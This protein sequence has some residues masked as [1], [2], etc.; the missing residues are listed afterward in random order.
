V[1]RFLDRKVGSKLGEK[2]LLGMA[3]VRL[4]E[5]AHFNMLACGEC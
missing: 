4:R 5:E 1:A 3:L 2:D